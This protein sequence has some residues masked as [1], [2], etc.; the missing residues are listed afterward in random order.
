MKIKISAVKKCGIECKV[1]RG[2]ALLQWA[3]RSLP[4]AP[5]H[6]EL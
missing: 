6:K 3:E 5:V 1:Q 4:L 2:N